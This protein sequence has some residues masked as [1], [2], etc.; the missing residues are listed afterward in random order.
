[1]TLIGDGHMAGVYLMSL[2]MKNDAIIQF[3]L[4]MGKVLASFNI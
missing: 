3:Q 4:S 2:N 1:M